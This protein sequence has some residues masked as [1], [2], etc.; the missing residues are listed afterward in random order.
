MRSDLLLLTT[1]FM[2]ICSAATS[3]KSILRF[4]DDPSGQNYVTLHPDFTLAQNEFSVCSWLRRQQIQDSVGVSWFSYT[5]PTSRAGGIQ[6][7]TAS[8]HVMVVSG[9]AYRLKF[10]T[11]TMHGEWY[12]MCYTWKSG[13]AEFYI[14]GVLVP[15][16]GLRP[17][18]R[19][20][21]GGTLVLGQGPACFD[22]Q[23]DQMGKFVGDVYQLN[24]FKKTLNLQDITE[25]F[26]NGRCAELCRALVYEV[27]LSWTDVL[28]KGDIKGNVT[29]EDG[30]C[31]T[32]WNV[33]SET[34]RRLGK[35]VLR[36]LVIK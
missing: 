18:G 5:A 13:Y 7:N 22:N 10:T 31:D 35:D 24:V 23:T 36:K 33:L 4:P 14:N 26:Y 3:S 6:L 11:R 19:V 8:F 30:E 16:T 28:K 15:L 1:M 29:N 20:S 17:I 21:V 12:H 32:L 25:M 27:V 2:S 34:A 9:V